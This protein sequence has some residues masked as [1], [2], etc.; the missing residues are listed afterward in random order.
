MRVQKTAHD[1]APCSV[2]AAIFD[3][4]PLAV[5]GDYRE[6]I[7]PWP[8]SLSRPERFQQAK[9]QGRETEHFQ[10]ETHPTDTS[11]SSPE[12]APKERGQ[13]KPRYGGSKPEPAPI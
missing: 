4:Q 7:R 5:I 11:A 2:F 6:Q 10:A 1:V 12:I 8:R 9:P 13:S 3:L